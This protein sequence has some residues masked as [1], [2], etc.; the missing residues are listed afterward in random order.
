MSDD[1]T[2]SEPTPKTSVPKS[3]PPI[4]VLLLLVLNLGA[5]GFVVF[6]LLTAP[7]AHAAPAAPPPAATG[8]EVSGPLMKLEPFV[9][10]LNEANATRYL[11]L[12]VELE[13]VTSKAKHAIDKAKQVI[14]DEML[15][16]LSGLNLAGT[17]GEQAKIKIRT[18]L[19]ARIETIVGPNQVKRMFFTEFVV[20]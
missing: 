14:R 2:A 13:L 9:V 15:S 7:A 3:K 11:K 12:G 19:M 5:S 8:H 1:A 10:N 6:K 20:Q 18:D 4:V 16:Y 17:L